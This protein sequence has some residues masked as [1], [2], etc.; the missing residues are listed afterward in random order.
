MLTYTFSKRE[1]VLLVVLAV[2]LIAVVWYELVFQGVQQQLDDL[3]GQIAAAQDEMVVDT[4]KAQRTKQMQEAIA[5]YQAQGVTP[6]SVPAYDNVQPL[7]A[8]LNATLSAST[9]YTLTFDDVDTS[10]GSLAKRGADLTFGATSYTSARSI[11][12]ALMEGPYPCSVDELVVT[13]NA[14]AQGTGGA[15]SGASGGDAF[16]VRAHLTFYERIEGGSSSPS[17]GSGTGDGTET[18]QNVGSSLGLT[19]AAPGTGT[20]YLTGQNDSSSSSFSK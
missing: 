4:T 5:A 17:E 7:M 13:D 18:A 8:A 15:A 19:T 9:R 11:L 16:S 12:N 6:T 14:A 2:M 10:D 3:D 1:K 20:N